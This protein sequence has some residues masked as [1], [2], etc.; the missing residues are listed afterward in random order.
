[1][2]E[3]H[4]TVDASEI[5]EIRSDDLTH[6]RPF[7]KGASVESAEI[8]ESQGWAFQIVFIPE[9]GSSGE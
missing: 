6:L 9:A 2:T 4:E 3:E 7:L 5:L 1:M 8:A